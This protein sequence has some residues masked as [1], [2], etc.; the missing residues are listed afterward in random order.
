M[1]PNHFRGIM[2]KDF[3]QQ[4]VLNALFLGHN[5]KSPEGSCFALALFFGRGGVKIEG[6]CF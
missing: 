4:R 5:N 2:S 6:P 3:R 1:G